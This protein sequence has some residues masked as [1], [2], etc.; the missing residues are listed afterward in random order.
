M[1]K[2]LFAEAQNA[3]GAFRLTLFLS[4]LNA[5]SI[6]LQAF[7]LSRIITLIFLG[8]QTL[9][10]VTIY[11]YALLAVVLSRALINGFNEYVV[12]QISILVKEDLRHRLIKHLMK[13]GPAY[14]KNERSGEL[15]LTATEGIEALDAYF[16]NYIPGLFTAVLVPL[17]ILFVVFPTDIVTF[18]ILLLTAPL[19]P[20]FMALIGM[21]AGRVARS[22]YLAMGRMS[23]HFMDV[24]QGLTTL[25]LFNRS[26]LQIKT[27]ARITDDFR[28][29]T[30]QVLRIAFISSFALEIIATLS[31]AIVAV[32]IGMRLLAG[33]ILFEQAL[34]LL[35]I[36]PD[37]YLPL[38]ALGTK[39]HAGTE[40]A[41]SAERIFDILD[42]PLPD[43]SDAALP[44]PTKLTV[45]FEAVTMIYESDTRA[46][47]DGVSFTLNQ[48]ERIAIVGASGSG[49]TTIANLLLRFST[50]TEGYIRVA[51]VDLQK[52]DVKAWRE[53]IAWVSQTPYI[54]NAS[55]MDNIRL[56]NPNATH[57]AVEQVA[58]LV[59]AHDFI[60]AM[61]EGYNT[62]VG[63]RGSR[64]SGGQAQRIAIA[65][66]FLKNAPIILLDEATSN[67]DY[68]TEAE[69]EGALNILL[70][71]RTALIIAHRLNTAFKADRILVMDKGVLVEQGTHTHLMAKGGIY[72]KLVESFGSMTYV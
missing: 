46:A 40:G 33:T 68:G 8:E 9:E 47:L 1:D 48:G 34:F 37:Y 43:M 20:F 10:D 42:T 28:D 12:S 26:H 63:E 25:K 24:L 31:V 15:V 52:L 16:K 50:P 7:F 64:L 39:F 70:E 19:I 2:R 66:A 35:V 14:V 56:G 69:V 11:F 55:L 58:K 61:P 6:L 22:N 41:A 44:L 21:A 51:D 13:L 72:R 65:R 17:T 62:I 57:E 54:F 60:M 36:A 67:L 3:R 59:K 30:M 27:I 38:R 71:N 49:K 4:M 29:T 18:I 5:I 53:K 45:T 23:A 32:E